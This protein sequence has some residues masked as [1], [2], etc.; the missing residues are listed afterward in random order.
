MSNKNKFR[1]FCQS[2]F[3]LAIIIAM[4]GVRASAQNPYDYATANQGSANG[5]AV[6]VQ[7][8]SPFDANAAAVQA[9]SFYRMQ[10]RAFCN[11]RNDFWRERRIL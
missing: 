5:V 7:A 1:L 11:V 9:G 2:L 6:P 4:S 10:I 3:V 8:T